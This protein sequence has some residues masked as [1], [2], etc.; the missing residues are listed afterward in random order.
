VLNAIYFGGTISPGMT[1]RPPTSATNCAPT[2]RRRSVLRHIR[3]APKQELK[4]RIL[5]AIMTSI[6][7]LSSTWTYKLNEAA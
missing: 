2:L 1:S 7:M 4:D 5:A 6:A 3:V